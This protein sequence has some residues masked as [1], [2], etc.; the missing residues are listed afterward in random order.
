MTSINSPGSLVFHSILMSCSS[1]IPVDGHDSS[2]DAT[3][4]MELMMWRIKEDAKVKR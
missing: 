4:C 2:E 3:A 1:L